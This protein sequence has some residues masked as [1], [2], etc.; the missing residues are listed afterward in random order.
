VSSRTATILVTDLVG[1]TELRV[2]LGEDRAE[3]LRR[4]H[5]GLLAET[6]TANGGEVV[7]GLGDGIL[8]LFSGAAEAVAAAVSIQ[9]RIAD[10]VERHPEEALSIRI[11]LSA[12]DVTLED[13]DCFGT[14]VVEASRLCAEAGGD[15]I[16]AADLVRLLARGR[17]D[18]QFVPAGERELKGLP[19]PVPVALVAW[20]RRAR[21]A[22]P[23]PAALQAAQ[24]FSFAGRVAER[25]LLVARWKAAAAGDPGLVVVSGEP[26]IGKTR[27][28]AE[29]ATVAHESG[30]TVLYGRSEEELDVPYRP[31]AEAL[32]H[33]VAHLAPEVVDDHLEGWGHD[34]GRLL[35]SVAA[36]PA[37]ASDP[38][39]ERLALFGAVVD[40]LG[41][42]GEEAPV[43]VVLDDLHWA[44]ESSLLLL[45]HLVRQRGPARM[46]VVGTYRD[47]D[48]ARTHP[49][50][51]A[52][53]DLRREAGIERVAL[54]G[55]DGDEVEAF[56]TLAGGGDVAP[57]DV[58][59]LAAMVSAETEGNPF[60]IGE[61]LVHLVESGALVQHEGRWQ[62]D[63]GLIEQIGLPEGIREVVGRR[64][65]DLP[66][67][68]DELLRVAAV[69][70]PAF[71][72]AVVAA[73]LGRDVDE[74][75]RGLDDAGGRRLV[76][77]D[78]D[79]LDRYRFAHALV[80]QT[81]LEEVSTSRRVRLHHRVGLAL[82]DRGAPAADLAHHFS[83]AAALADATKAMV[84]AGRA[85]EEAGGRLAFEQAVRFRRLA[86]EAE[87]LI[88]PPDAGRRAEELLE[89]GEVRNLAGEP[90]DAREDFVAAADLARGIGRTDL[91]ARAAVGYGGEGAVWLD[92]GDTV[93][94]A[95]LD[96]ALAMLPPGPSP[97]R[98]CALAQR[99]TWHL[100]DADP[101]ER[102]RISAEAVAMAEESADLRALHL[103][104]S[105][106]ANT[107][108]AVGD[109]QELLQ[110]TRRLEGLARAAG[111]DPLRF[112]AL[113]YGNIARLIGNDL[114]QARALQAEM[115]GL[116][117][118]MTPANHWNVAS[119][120][121][122][123]ALLEGR[124]DDV[125]TASDVS[126]AAFGVTGA[127][128]AASI[129]YRL[130]F[131]QGDDAGCAARVRTMVHDQEVNVAPWPNLA[132]AALLEGD[133]GGAEAALRDWH[134]GMFPVIPA[135]FRVH[136]A[137]FA[138]PT[139]VALGLAELHDDLTA[140]LRPRR[141]TWATWTSEV[142]M[143]LTDHVLG[144]L[145]LAFGDRALG[146]EE[147]RT[148]IADYR[149]GEV[150][151]A[152]AQALADL[153]VL[154][155]DDDARCEA[156][157]LAAELGMAG[158]TRRLAT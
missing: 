21:D 42:A 154:A 2:A 62:G 89:L 114:P 118:R 37:A 30:A 113:Y 105:A 53:A 68:T 148:A 115:E 36:P 66:E 10:H 126:S 81:L 16:L 109:W 149:T 78:A 17:G 14:P 77:E 26:G 124:W 86:L 117:H 98:A 39:A 3:A 112:L 139:A 125:V 65:A 111:D 52:L 103:S 132:W 13:G 140:E 97:L 128:L 150:R 145:D 146:E 156:R 18:H 67:A 94:P 84:Y 147:L 76:I 158:I 73:A 56:L 9:Q 11:G 5:D 79:A 123:V 55:L 60:F 134:L 141:G 100:L 46:L 93:G 45:R 71:D 35:P 25:E 64:L 59:E 96:E 91:L 44:D 31:W 119:N 155:G 120:R 87:E 131:L 104:L 19:D 82:E 153:A 74:V 157:T 151:A 47:T 70:G 57:D 50:A 116:V 102:L 4:I 122:C 75:V 142:A 58:A 110:V 51:A 108:C 90:V 88:Q 1:S 8:A 29:L 49:L 22:A 143:F 63:R 135:P 129:E 152:L 23:I 12:G 7:K 40:L 15:E 83:E 136:A 85:A 34:L 106:R 121:A 107:L 28:V 92:F 72:A 33:L 32:Q 127:A 137:A 48:L 80:R 54:T 6:V 24:W 27:L 61:V 20:T 43:L 130:A 144:M 138:T 41:R 101:T 38:D 133:P 69:V 99:S 95:L